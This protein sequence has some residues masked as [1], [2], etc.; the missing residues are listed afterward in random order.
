MSNVIHKKSYFSIYGA[1]FALSVLNCYFVVAPVV[2]SMDTE[3]EKSDEIEDKRVLRGLMP[4]QTAAIV[5]LVLRWKV[6][7]FC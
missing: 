1:G 4:D 6:A 2:H 7:M 3:D 5:R